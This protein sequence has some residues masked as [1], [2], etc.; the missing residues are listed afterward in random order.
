MIV[1]LAIHVMDLKIC[2]ASLLE[3]KDP[4][5][6]VMIVVLAIHVME[7][8]IYVAPFLEQKYLLSGVMIVVLYT[9]DVTNVLRAVQWICD[10]TLRT[11]VLS[12]E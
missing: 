12:P 8:E 4:L 3:Q 10:I 7:L 6:R 9:D 5:S 11:E 1:V 2:V